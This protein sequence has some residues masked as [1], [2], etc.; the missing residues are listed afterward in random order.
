MATVGRSCTC[1]APGELLR[2][3]IPKGFLSDSTD[4]SLATLNWVSDVKAPPSLL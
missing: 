1:M 2:L 4:T 3:R